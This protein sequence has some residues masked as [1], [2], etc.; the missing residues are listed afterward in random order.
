MTMALKT[1][2]GTKSHST[3][4]RQAGSA[5]IMTEF[6]TS[7]RTRRSM[8]SMKLERLNWD[9]HG[10]FG[11]S[12]TSSWQGAHLDGGSNSDGTLR[13]GAAI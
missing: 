6:K 5:E 2:D 11:K 1:L 13:S 8:P 7:R 9:G 10:R 3:G 12:T 4:Y